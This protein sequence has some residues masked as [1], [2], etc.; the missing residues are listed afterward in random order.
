MVERDKFAK[1]LNWVTMR[2]MLGLK[3][4]IRKRYGRGNFNARIKLQMIYSISYTH[5]WTTVPMEER[6]KAMILA[7]L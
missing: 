7:C 3:A 4:S 5:V 1:K 6:A 2:M